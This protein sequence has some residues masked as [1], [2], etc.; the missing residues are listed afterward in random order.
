MLYHS[1]TNMFI[2]TLPVEKVA[3]PYTY[4]LTNVSEYSQEWHIIQ[5]MDHHINTMCC[6]K[7]AGTGLGWVIDP[8]FSIWQ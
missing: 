6:N 4:I 1:E 8:A 2:G 7:A 5:W 3:H